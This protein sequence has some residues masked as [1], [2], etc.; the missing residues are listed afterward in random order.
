MALDIFEQVAIDITTTVAQSKPGDNAAWAVLVT[1]A[2]TMG[3]D[4][5][6]ADFRAVLAEEEEHRAR[7]EEL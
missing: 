3:Q 4:E 6:A 1:L 5:L 2:E 7:L